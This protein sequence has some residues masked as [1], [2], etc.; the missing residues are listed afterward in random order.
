[1]RVNE[2]MAAIATNPEAVAMAERLLENHDRLLSFGEIV[3]MVYNKFFIR[4]EA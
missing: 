4:K 2:M 1:M 3:E